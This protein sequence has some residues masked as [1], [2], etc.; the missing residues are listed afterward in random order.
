M[1]LL[2]SILIILFATVLCLAG[3]FIYFIHTPKPTLPQLSA[4]IQSDTLEVG[5]M[6]RAFTYYVPKTQKEKM[7]LVLVFHGSVQSPDAIR[8]YTGYEFEHLADE[9]GF[10]V[11]YPKGYKKN[12]NDCR[13][14]A[15]YPARAENIDDKG[16]VKALIGRFVSGY[17]ADPKRVFAVGYSNGGHF[18]L[19]LAQETPDD[20]AGIAVISA[21]FP[22]KDNSDCTASSTPLPVLFMNGTC[23]P[24]NP[25]DGGVV[26]LFGIGNRGTVLSSFESAFHF[27]SLA[28]YLD[29]DVQTRTLHSDQPVSVKIQEWKKE[30]KPPVILYSL[31]NGGHLIP[32]PYY[33][34]PRILGA[35][36]PYFNGPEAI[37]NFFSGF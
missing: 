32:Q 21:N 30:G 36:A 13:S 9:K 18:A 5:G 26:S 27:A 33:R 37:W 11:V 16:F 22:T 28:G 7:P 12:W 29:S 2:R 34:A 8:K 15:T 17:K 23:D 35:N 25:Y 24:L 10:I 19:R 14:T 6:T 1:S 31:V 4:V 20:I 3:L